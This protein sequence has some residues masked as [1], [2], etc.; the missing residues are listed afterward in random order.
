MLLTTV[1]TVLGLLP[2]ALGLNVDLIHRTITFGAPATQWWR[3]LATAIVFGLT[4]ATLL[5]LLVTPA[6]LMLR[7]DTRM[8]WILRRM[9]RAA[10]NS[11]A[12]PILQQLH[13]T[14]RS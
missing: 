1:T 6:A 13:R 10:R 12:A 3:Q 9:R 2:M 14:A 7:E 4:F 5:T 8:K 11:K